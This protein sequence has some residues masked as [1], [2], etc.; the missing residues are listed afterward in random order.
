VSRSKLVLVIQFNAEKLPP[1]KRTEYTI[2]FLIDSVS[3]EKVKG[4]QFLIILDT[5]EGADSTSLNNSTFRP[6]I[7]FMFCMDIRTNSDNFP[8]Q[9]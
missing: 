7:V 3:A 6:H 9:H 2:N 8:V 4:L 1:I 5:V